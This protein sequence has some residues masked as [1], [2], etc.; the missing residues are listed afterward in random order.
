[1]LCYAT[2]PSAVLSYVM[3]HYVTLCYA[4]LRYN[5]HRRLLKMLWAG[6]HSAHI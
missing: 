1:M 3:A 5:L 6:G 4:L 2:L